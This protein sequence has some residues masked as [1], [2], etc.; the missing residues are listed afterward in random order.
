MLHPCFISYVHPEGDWARAAINLAV[1][2]LRS[3]LEVDFG[4]ERPPY[5]D[6][7]RLNPGANHASQLAQ[8]ICNSACMVILYYPAYG[9]SDYC[10]RELQAMRQIEQCRRRLLGGKLDAY[11]MFIPIV[12]RGRAQDLPDFVHRDC[13]WLDYSRQLLTSRD[14]SGTTQVRERFFRVVDTI[15][16]LCRVLDEA[17]A[18]RGIDCRGFQLPASGATS[19]P[20]APPELPFPGRA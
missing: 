4:R 7:D 19:G 3:A 20:A 11:R 2:A 12:L 10:Q 16:A 9:Y 14:I 15:S 18:A 1:N 6:T 8:A 13:V 5:I 17:Q